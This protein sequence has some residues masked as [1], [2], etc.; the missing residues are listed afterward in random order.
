MVTYGLEGVINYS[1]N[2]LLIGGVLVVTCCLD[3]KVSYF[4]INL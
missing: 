2:N 3:E 4:D 1:D